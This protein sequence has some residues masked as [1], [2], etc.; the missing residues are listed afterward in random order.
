MARIRMAIRGLVKAPF[1]SL[2]IILSVG[3]GV[4]ANT[5]VFSL[6]RQVLLQTLPVPHPERLVVLS[7]PGEFKDGS[8]RT[9][10]SGGM[11]YIFSY[12]MFRELEA[13]AHSVAA[14]YPFNAN[15]SLRDATLATTA[16]IVS[17]GYFPTLGLRPALGRTIAPAD[18]NGSAN[19]VAVLSYGFWYDH[20]GGDIGV[21]NRPLKLNGQTFTGSGTQLD[22]LAE[23]L[24]HRFTG[25]G[26]KMAS[27]TI[28]SAGRPGRTRERCC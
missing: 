15:L 6:V 10:D 2:I 7:S 21:L 13:R 18:D 24:T 12:P 17:G 25:R 1:L 9:G 3:L 19:P 5:A 4:G 14:F 16:M 23:T 20:L 11:D 22:S 27:D 8:S 28:F 26:E